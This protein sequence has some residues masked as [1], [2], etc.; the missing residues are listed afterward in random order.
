MAD[1][2]GPSSPPNIPSPSTNIPPGPD[3]Q[4]PAE[5]KEQNRG[6]Q[7]YGP[8]NLHPTQSSRHGALVSQ[9]PAPQYMKLA[10]PGPLGLLSFALT[11]F[12]LGLY[13][14]GAGYVFLPVHSLS[15]VGAVL[16]EQTPAFQSSRKRRSQPSNLRSRSLLWR[17]SPVN[18]RNPRIPRRKHL[19]FNSPLLLRRLLAQLRHVPPAL[20]RHRSRLQ[21]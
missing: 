1:N 19:R 20:P 8:A 18:C 9:V 10:N 15:L 4:I 16:I 12:A 6:Q 21:R 11:T 5:L 17:Y 13:E 3:S 14:C 7:A 2:P